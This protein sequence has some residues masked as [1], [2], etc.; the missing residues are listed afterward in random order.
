MPKLCEHGRGTNRDKIGRCIVCRN[1][2]SR[3][4]SKTGRK[5]TWSR[6]ASRKL[7]MKDPAAALWKG[8]KRRATD[9]GLDF[10]IEVSDIH[11]PD[12]CPLLNIEI[13]IGG[14][15]ETLG[16]APA[17]DRIENHKGYVK[18]NIWVISHRAN[19]AKR[20]LSVAEFCYAADVMRNLKCASY[21]IWR[22]VAGLTFAPPGREDTQP[23]GQPALPWLPGVPTE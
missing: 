14:S 23:I 5:R 16:N 12:I 10:N 11:V 1:A 4:Y 13:I 2:R 9:R 7:R 6:E 19:S 3:E 21:L 8:A 18:G 17:L 15:R 20:D 22:P